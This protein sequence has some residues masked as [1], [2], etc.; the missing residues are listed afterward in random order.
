MRHV[1]EF[2]HDQDLAM[3]DR[4]LL[5]VQQDG[6]WAKVAIEDS[7]TLPEGTVDLRSCTGSTRTWHFMQSCLSGITTSV[8]F[9]LDMKT[10]Y[11]CTR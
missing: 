10:D 9:V 7:A 1:L 4:P 2:E 6:K 11:H 5:R 8:P 3:S